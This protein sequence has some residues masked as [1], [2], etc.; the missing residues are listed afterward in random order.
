MFFMISNLGKH[1][2]HIYQFNTPPEVE[3]ELWSVE[4]AIS[5]MNQC[6]VKACHFYSGYYGEGKKLHTRVM[7]IRELKN[8]PDIHASWNLVTKMFLQIMLLLQLVLQ[9]KY[10]QASDTIVPT[11]NSMM[12]EKSLLSNSCRLLLNLLRTCL[13]MSHN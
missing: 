6:A 7:I 2:C 5:L 10:I 12:S 9:F 8:R 4:H 3:L 13:Q 11:S 1:E